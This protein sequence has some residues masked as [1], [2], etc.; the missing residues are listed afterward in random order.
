MP[1]YSYN[2]VNFEIYIISLG[3]WIKFLWCKFSWAWQDPGKFFL[4][5]PKENL[6]TSKAKKIST[7]RIKFCA[8]KFYAWKIPPKKKL[9][10]SNMKFFR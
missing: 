9:E 5:W 1:I 2:I 8:K 10:F 3:A 4:T 7:R 6:I